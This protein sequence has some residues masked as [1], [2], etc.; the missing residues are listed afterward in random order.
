[1]FHICQKDNCGFDFF[2]LTDLIEKNWSEYKEKLSKIKKRIE[3][4]TSV[5]HLFS[6]RFI[7]FQ[8]GNQNDF[9]SN[10]F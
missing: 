2:I 3:N 8:A 9:V 5:C 1:M 7:D 6:L 4:S 10:V